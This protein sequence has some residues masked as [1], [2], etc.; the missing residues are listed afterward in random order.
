[1]AQPSRLRPLNVAGKDAR[2]TGLVVDQSF[3]AERASRPYTRYCALSYN[4][5][6]A[7]GDGVGGRQDGISPAPVP[8]KAGREPD[9]LYIWY[10]RQRGAWWKKWRWAIITL[11]VLVLLH[12]VFDVASGIAMADLQSALHSTAVDLQEKPAYYS[13]I[14][15][16]TSFFMPTVPF[17]LDC[18]LLVVMTLAA[19]L[20]ADCARL[21]GDVLV[22]SPGNIYRRKLAL[23]RKAIWGWAMLWFLTPLALRVV[24]FCLLPSVLGLDCS[25]FNVFMS[26][27]AFGI[28][29]VIISAVFA[30]CL[31]RFTLRTTPER[32]LL[33]GVVIP[34]IVYTAIRLVFGNLVAVVS[35]QLAVPDISS[36]FRLIDVLWNVYLG[37]MPHF[38]VPF[39]LIAIALLWGWNNRPPAGYTGATAE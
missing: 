12:F 23:A 26:A 14:I 39:G 25:Y 2:A 10:R 36:Q 30:E 15:T 7:D 33:K 20:A 3:L 29:L 6:M 17:W 38:A 32:I 9:V 35:D 16:G 1:M 34:F 21:P 11:A 37:E 22:D 4:P 8:A 28:S 5:Y 19:F 31:V 13:Q 24:V 27:L 18:L